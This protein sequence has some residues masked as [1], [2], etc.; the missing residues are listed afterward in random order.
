V[1][2][3]ANGERLGVQHVLL[4]L[5]ARPRPDPAAELFDALGVDRAEVRQRLRETS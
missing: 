3:H 1:R 5:L 4:A 2:K